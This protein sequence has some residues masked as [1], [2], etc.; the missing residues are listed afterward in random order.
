[1]LQFDPDFW[2]P[3]IKELKYL[4]NKF[5]VQRARSLHEKM[6]R[7][8][9]KVNTRREKSSNRPLDERDAAFASHAITYKK[10]DRSLGWYKKLFEPKGNLLSGD[11]TPSYAAL[12]SKTIAAIA[13]A[14]PDLRVFLLLRDP[15][16]RTWSNFNMIKRKELTGVSQGVAEPNAELV[17]AFQQQMSTQEL[18]KY[19]QK[20]RVA[21][22]AFPTSI[23]E[24]WCRRF[25]GSQISIVFFEDIIEAPEEVMGRFRKDLGLPA[26]AAGDN[27]IATNFNRKADRLKQEM[28]DDARAILVETFRDEMLRCAE[29]FGGAA[30]RWPLRNGIA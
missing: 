18:V 27:R 30:E 4:T 22:G 6:S 12:N 9:S 3:P 2:M 13:K 11:I 25:D 28:S 23:F 24:R 29:R 5:P 26:A 8:L 10:F 17:A 7:N 19:L 20:D 15:V 1:M 21:R 14:L 16:A